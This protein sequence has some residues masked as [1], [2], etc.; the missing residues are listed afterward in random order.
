[1]PRKYCSETPNIVCKDDEVTITHNH[2]SDAVLYNSEYDERK[3]L[4]EKIDNTTKSVKSCMVFFKTIVDDKKT[5]IKIRA[6]AASALQ[7][8][9]TLLVDLNSRK[10]SK[11]VIQ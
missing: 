10:P 9:E 6:A 1:M 5:D 4:R 3:E 2:R 8:D 7:E 11:C